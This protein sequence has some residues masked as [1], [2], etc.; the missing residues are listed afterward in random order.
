MMKRISLIFSA[1][2]IIVL[3]ICFLII[4]KYITKT[5]GYSV[6][7]TEKEKFLDCLKAKKTIYFYDSAYCPD[8]KIQESVLSSYINLI[9]KV[10]CK[11]NPPQCS[12]LTH[13]PAWLIAGNIYYGSFGA[14]ELSQLAKC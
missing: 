1:I 6:L 14:E 13:V 11:N 12:K 4:S 3:I 9:N 5:A 10:D 7:D 8:C 2:A